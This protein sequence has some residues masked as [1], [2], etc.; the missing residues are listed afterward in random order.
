MSHW[1][2]VDTEGTDYLIN[3]VPIRIYFVHNNY[4]CRS[5]KPR[6]QLVYAFITLGE[7]AAYAKSLNKNKQYM[8]CPVCSGDRPPWLNRPL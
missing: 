4:A 5:A 6:V 2:Y 7:A 1:F 3:N 8:Q